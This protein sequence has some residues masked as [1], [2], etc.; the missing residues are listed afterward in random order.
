MREDGTGGGSGVARLAIA[1]AASGVALALAM[2][3]ARPPSVDAKV[4]DET[5]PRSTI[6]LPDA[7]LSESGSTEVAKDV[8]EFGKLEVKSE[9][10]SNAGVRAALA[11]DRGFQ[12]NRILL[13]TL[14]LVSILCCSETASSAMLSH[15]TTSS[16]RTMTMSS[17]STRHAPFSTNSSSRQG[18]TTPI[19]DA[20][21]LLRWRLLLAH[22]S[23][24]NPSESI[25][26][27]GNHLDFAGPPLVLALPSTPTRA[28]EPG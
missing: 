18:S 21:C 1:A 17:P 4:P 2:E 11:T 24:N 8:D 13:L 16:P 23:N 26:L 12:S 10:A 9:F 25:S 5:V 27:L 6:A 3:A 28:S 22:L 14:A 7:L 15:S 20:R 19:F